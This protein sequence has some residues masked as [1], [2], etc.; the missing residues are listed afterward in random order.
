M[1]KSKAIIFL[2]KKEIQEIFDSFTSCFNIRINYFSPEIEELKVGLHKPVCKYCSLIQNSLL[3]KD[4]CIESD[5]VHCKAAVVKRDTHHYTCHAGL[6]EAIHPVFYDNALLGFIVMGQFRNTD[7]IQ[8]RLTSACKKYGIVPD[9][10]QAA[11]L[12]VPFF[13]DAQIRNTLNLFRILVK[14]IVTQHMISRKGNMVLNS[15][16]HI[17]EEHV[18]HQ[19]TLTGAGRMV[20]KSNSYI[21]HIFKNYFGKSFTQMFIEMKLNK[22]DEIF[23]ATPDRTISEV[24][25]ALGYEDPLYFSRIYKKY[26]KRS[27]KEYKR[28]YLDKTRKE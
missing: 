10:L 7:T 25:Y 21:S 28:E 6:Q 12:K 26:R 23:R 1:P 24:A 22:A 13:A 11:F 2:F 14:Y 4:S 18:T 17:M 19:L 27:P 3:L 9:E 16:V 8:P 15:I 20:G 5:K